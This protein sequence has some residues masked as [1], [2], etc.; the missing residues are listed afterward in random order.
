ML[1]RVVEGEIK[2]QSE[3]PGSRSHSLAGALG[4]EL[5]GLTLTLL[6]A[7]PRQA[8]GFRR[9]LLIL[10]PNPARQSRG[11]S[12]THGGIKMLAPDGRIPTK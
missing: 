5:R 10:C 12:L 7:Q 6:D 11:A 1:P 2:A 8:L 3:T 9:S 4:S